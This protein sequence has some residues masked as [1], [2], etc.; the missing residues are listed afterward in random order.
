M[1]KYSFST[2]S[3][4]DMDLLFSETVSTDQDFC[5]FIVEQAGLT[6]TDFEI[7][8]VELSK[9][10]SKLGESDITIILDASGEKVGL[11]IE[12]KI[13]AVA[14]PDQHERYIKRGELGIK[15]GD[16]SRFEVCVFCPKKYYNNNNEAKKYEHC[17][18]Y[19]ECKAFFDSKDD[20]L[21]FFRSQ[22]ISQAIQKAKKPPSTEVNSEAN[23]FLR[24][25]IEYQRI[26]FPFL[27]LSTKEDR[28]GWWTDYRTNLGNVYI[29]HK[30]REGYV[31]LTFPGANDKYDNVLRIAEW[32]RDHRFNNIKTVKTK[33][34]A[35]I[36]MIVP[37]LDIKKGFDAI[38]KM[39]LDNC[40]EA[41][42][43]LT[44]LANMIK[45][46]S[47]LVNID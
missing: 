31:D 4:R 15:Q 32:A 3:E 22:Q 35:M 19:E 41:V 46:G 2:V 23:A 38:D 26:H 36:R 28:N 14:M 17:I 43:E 18:T 34:S 5:R 24:R 37:S 45:I 47:S 11:L 21:S 8:S 16:Y 6:E 30:L 9:E 39:N 44:D 40:F 12:D 27:D 7:N 29:N 13:D 20:E 42:K 1:T 33:K 25:Y 10:D